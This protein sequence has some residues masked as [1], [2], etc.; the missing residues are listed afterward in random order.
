MFS[1]FGLGVGVISFNEGRHL[2]EALTRFNYFPNQKNVVGEMPPIFSTVTFTPEIAEKIIVSG[3][4][5]KRKLGFDYV[6]YSVTRHNNIPRTL[7]LMH[8]V[9]A[10]HLAKVVSDN[11]EDIKY[12]KG[13]ELSMIR[14]EQHTD[15]RIMIMNYED[16]DTKTIRALEDSFGKAFRVDADISNCFGSI[17]THSIPWAVVGFDESKAKLKGGKG[18]DRE[19]HWSDELDYFQR[20]ARRNETQ[21]I[22]IGPGVSS[23]VVELILGR[24]DKMLVDSGYC[25]RR[26]I[27]DYIAFCS[28]HEE[29]QDFIRILGVELAKYKLGLNLQKTK[30]TKL[31]EPLSDGWVS[32]LGA[33]TPSTIVSD[34]FSR[35]KLL[36]FEVI[37][38]LDFAVRLNKETPDGS[39]LKYAI[40]TVVHSLDS[41]AVKSVFLYVFNLAWHYPVLIPYL[42]LVV[43]GTDV[44][45]SEYERY[46]NDLIVVNAKSRRSDG[47]VWSLY[48]LIE[49]GL[50]VSPDAVQGII[51]SAD[52]VALVCLL[53]LQPD[54]E[55]LK[56]FVDDI[57]GASEYVIDQYWLLL[58]QYYLV[59]K[60]DNPYKDDVFSLLRDYDVDFLKGDARA[61]LAE[62]YCD[63]LS[64]PFAEKEMVFEEFDVFVE[65]ARKERAVA[66][67]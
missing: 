53:K 11:W 38:Y 50:S 17:Y 64:N 55:L 67:A 18:N 19:R 42:G 62:Q 33:V 15:G 31:P 46:F 44:D 30:I 5:K 66:H 9:A 12:I 37:T 52:C 27:D 29:A 6:S 24:V 26:Y 7:G 36:T 63:Y 3:A 65:S 60:I 54:N 20:S 4:L 56:N 10:A 25:F 58:Y 59:G 13:N 16:P 39:V 35:R 43:R 61:T 21:G 57:L 23:I 2:Y 32:Q 48:Y 40:A 51:D 8:P 1:F 22:P 45:V 49:Y 41:S 28:T 47:M 14:P 34:S